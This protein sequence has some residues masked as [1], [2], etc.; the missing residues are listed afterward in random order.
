MQ[1]PQRSAALLSGQKRS[2]CSRKL[3]SQRRTIAAAGSDEV[4]ITDRLCEAVLL[5]MVKEVPRVIADP[6]H[7]EARANIMWAGMVAHNNTCGVGRQQDWA[8]HDIEHELSAMYDC[9][10]GAGLAVIFP[11]WMRYTVEHN[12]MRFA[13][14]AV[15]LWGCQM[16]F[17]NP[18]NT[19]IAGIDAFKCFLSSIG[20]PVSFA[21]LGA[22]EEDIPA[23]AEK[24][25]YGDG[26]GGS[27]GGFVKLGKEDV[28]KIFRLAL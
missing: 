9:A 7:Y 1:F 5:T 25:C 24:S 2:G 16:D 6:D 4:E 18:M 8:S 14:L 10:H 28:E 12:P 19:A 11:A 13:Q 15:R 26:R 27:L 3:N 20:M 22:K 21:E 17:E 23:M